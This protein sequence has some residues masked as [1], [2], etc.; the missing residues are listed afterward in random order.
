MDELVSKIVG[1]CFPFPARLFSSIVKDVI[2]KSEDYGTLASLFLQALLRN[3]KD[4]PILKAWLVAKD[5]ELN[6]KSARRGANSGKAGN[7][8]GCFV[9]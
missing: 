6:K 4:G 3:Q 5:G 2:S 8:C 1:K 9:A 7:N